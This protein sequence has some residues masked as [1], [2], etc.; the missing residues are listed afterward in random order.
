M[1]RTACLQREIKHLKS[2]LQASKDEKHTM[3]NAEASHKLL[4]ENKQLQDEANTALNL[5]SQIEMEKASLHD[6]MRL[7]RER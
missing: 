6:E 7:M 1:Q 2:E 3:M 4:D 5:M